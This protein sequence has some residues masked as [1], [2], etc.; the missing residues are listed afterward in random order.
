[1]QVYVTFYASKQPCVTL[2]RRIRALGFS[3]QAIAIAALLDLPNCH[4]LLTLAWLHS[5]RG[6]RSQEL[7]PKI[8]FISLFE[9]LTAYLSFLDGIERS[10]R[11]VCLVSPTGES[12]RV[13]HSKGYQG[14]MSCTRH[15]LAGKPPCL[16]VT[17]R[18]V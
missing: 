9:Y 13:L 7:A 1:M 3:I 6:R 10:W 12:L 17:A 5:L 16:D 14:Q 8:L 15:T 18:E 2:G 4:L 11:V